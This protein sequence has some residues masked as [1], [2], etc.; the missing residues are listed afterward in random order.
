MDQDLRLHRIILLDGLASRDCT[1]I[2]FVKP[3]NSLQVMHKLLS[4]SLI[5]NAAQSQ[6]EA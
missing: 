6:Q 1:S 5:N 3:S 4:L 2:R